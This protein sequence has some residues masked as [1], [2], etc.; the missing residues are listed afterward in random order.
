LTTAESGSGDTSGYVTN[1]TAGQ[2]PETQFANA[3][4]II[5]GDSRK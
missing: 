3:V 2:L 4:L 1:A 5:A